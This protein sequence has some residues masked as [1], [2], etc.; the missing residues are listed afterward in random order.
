[1]LSRLP[2]LAAAPIVALLVAAPTAAAAEIQVDRPCYADP[3][4][5]A[6]TIAL[7]GSGFAPNAAY[8]VLLDGQP[9]QGGTGN[10]DASGAI[11]GSLAAPSLGSS[12][13][14]SRYQH[15]Y[16][17]TAQ[18]ASGGGPTATFAVSKLFA[19]FRPTSGNPKTL[20]VRFALYGFG[21]AGDAAPT[22]YLHYVAPNGKLKKTYRLGKGRG[23]CG[24]LKTSLRRLFPFS[25][26]RGAWNLQFDT[27]R[28]YKPG[29]STSPFLFYT[30]GVTVKAKR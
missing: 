26:G 9:L 7:T 13:G 25:A 30:L 11:A 14:G 18:D 20:K 28:A 12:T 3:S 6:D 24:S 2:S 10:A 5:R 15:S 4:Q 27:S 1:M 19:T 29:L 21:L 8:Q 17:L 16:S 22:I 23:P